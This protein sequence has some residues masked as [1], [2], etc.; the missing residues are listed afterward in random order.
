MTTVRI[1]HI[2]PWPGK[3]EGRHGFRVFSFLVVLADDSGGQ[4]PQARPAV[5][6]QVDLG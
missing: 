3:R 1:A 4:G 5:V 2:E 6:K